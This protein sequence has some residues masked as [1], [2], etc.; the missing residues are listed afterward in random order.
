[1]V[2]NLLAV[3]VEKYLL[4]QY[5]GTSG[6]H[7]L[8]ADERRVKGTQLTCFTS[9]KVLRL[10]ALLV[11]SGVKRLLELQAEEGRMKGTQFACFTSTKVQIMT[12]EELPA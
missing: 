2:L 1:M 12:P 5:K 4:Y 9:T 11:Q 6:R 10:L 7:Q 8:Q 3:L